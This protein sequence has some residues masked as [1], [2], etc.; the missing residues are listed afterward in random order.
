MISNQKHYDNIHIYRISSNSLKEIITDIYKILP[1]NSF[2]NTNKIYNIKSY[3]E[4]QKNSDYKNITENNNILYNH[5]KF[6]ISFILC[7]NYKST[8]ITI[9]EI[10]SNNKFIIELI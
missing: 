8:I 2:N 5:L 7:V 10:I 3:Y 6:I 1:H 4:Y 9:D